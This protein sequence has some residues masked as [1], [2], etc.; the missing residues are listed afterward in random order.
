MPGLSA[1]NKDGGADVFTV[2]CVRAGSCAAG[3]SY[4]DRHGHSQGY[5]VSEAG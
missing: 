1:L 3:G 2:S 5:V 4:T